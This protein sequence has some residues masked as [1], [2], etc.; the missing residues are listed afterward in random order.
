MS[1]DPPRAHIQA[2]KPSTSHQI[3]NS[4]VEARSQVNSKGGATGSEVK[5]ATGQLLADAQVR[6]LTREE[7]AAA[8]G[9]QATTVARWE[10]ECG[11]ELSHRAARD[12][13]ARRQQW[14]RALTDASQR[15][16]SSQQLATELGL[17]VDAV[18]K[19]QKLLHIEL[20]SDND[21]DRQAA[22]ER[23]RELLRD[24]ES[25]Q[26]TREK[27]A[28]E[29]QVEVHAVRY[30][31]KRCDIELSRTFANARQD[32][33]RHW[34]QVL[35]EARHRSQ[36][37]QQVAHQEQVTTATVINWERR[38]GVSLLSLT[39]RFTA[40]LTEA[41]RQGL[42]REQLAEQLGVQ[43]PTITTWERRTGVVLPRPET[44]AR[45]DQA[46]RWEQLLSDAQ[47]AGMTRE[48]LASAE[49]VSPVTVRAW[50]RRVGRDLPSRVVPPPSRARQWQQTLATAQQQGLL[51]DDVAASEHVQPAT[52]RR[53]ERTWGIELASAAA[54]KRQAGWERR[55]E[56]LTFAQARGHTREDVAAVAGVTVWTVRTWETRCGIVLPLARD[57]ANDVRK[58]HW[59]D[60]LQDARNR[61]RTRDEVA[62][63]QDVR[64]ETVRAWESRCGIP[65]KTATA[66]DR[67]A[68]REAWTKIL[69]SAQARGLTRTQL[70]AAEGI[71]GAQVRAWERRCDVSLPTLRDRWHTTLSSARQLD[72]VRHEVALAQSAS[73]QLVAHWERRCGIQLITLRQR[74]T[75]ALTAAEVQGLTREE[76]AHTHDSSTE[77]VYQWERKLEIGLDSSSTRDRSTRQAQLEEA[78]ERGLTPEE[79]ADELKLDIQ[80]VRHLAARTGVALAPSR[81][82]RTRRPAPEQLQQLIDEHR[83]AHALAVVIGVAS[84]T[85]YRWCR[86]AD[87]EL[88]GPAP[89]PWDDPARLRE[90]VNNGLTPAAIAEEAD[91]SPTTIRRWLHEYG[92]SAH[93]SSTGWAGHIIAERHEGDTGHGVRNIAY[94]ALPTRTKRL[95]DTVRVWL[96][97]DEV[98]LE[99]ATHTQVAA[100]VVA[101]HRH[102]LAAATIAETTY[103]VDRYDELAGTPRRGEEM[104]RTLHTI[105]QLWGANATPRR[106]VAVPLV[107]LRQLW[108]TEPATVIEGARWQMGQ[109]DAEIQLRLLRIWLA[110]V[111]NH[112]ARAQTPGH[113]TVASLVDATA[114]TIPVKDSTETLHTGH[115]P[116]HAMCPRCET[117]QLLA[118]AP[119][120]DR[121]V[122]LEKLLPTKARLLKRWCE[123]ARLP[124][125]AVTLGSARVTV[126]SLLWQRTRDVVAV[127]RLL[128]HSDPGGPVTRRYIQTLPEI[129]GL[130]RLDVPVD[131][132]LAY[133]TAQHER[134]AT[135]MRAA[136]TAPLMRLAEALESLPM[137]SRQRPQTNLKPVRS[138][139]RWWAA[140]VSGDLGVVDAGANPRSPETVL[141]WAATLVERVGLRAVTVRI[142]VRDLGE[143]MFPNHPSARDQCLALA[144][145]YLQR[146]ARAER[147]EIPATRPA[148]FT[149]QQA[150]RWVEIC[151]ESDEHQ[152]ARLL[153]W[154]W[155]TRTRPGSLYAISPEDIS[156]QVGGVAEVVITAGTKRRRNEM[157]THMYTVPAHAHGPVPLVPTLQAPGASIVD[158]VLIRPTSTGPQRTRRPACEDWQELIRVL[159]AAGEPVP[160]GMTPMSMRHSSLTHDW[161]TTGDLL[162]VQRVAGHASP[163]TTHHYLTTVSVEVRSAAAFTMSSEVH[164]AWTVDLDA[165]L[166]DLRAPELPEPPALPL[167]H[168]SG[169]DT[170]G[171]HIAGP[172]PQTGPER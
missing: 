92:M 121:S 87:V 55:A 117:L 97:R 116:D 172:I 32:R 40:S 93:R 147:D 30:W 157:G 167:L 15:A 11:I 150:A 169:H 138:G 27:L 140:F 19:W 58:R 90:A 161:Q 47:A 17:S 120:L 91:T 67:K 100:W 86:Q 60:T 7:L 22:I 154:G 105:H 68:E 25:R 126:A 115:T 125:C 6:N 80:A 133:V 21:R 96:D 46:A 57:Q 123:A 122:P 171:G 54:S 77:I 35:E 162:W 39:E 81:T 106:T 110:L 134:R 137:T 156:P 53:W 131:G 144:L 29:Q 10:R 149:V 88:P 38:C 166:E 3:G 128:G 164:R 65:L 2:G 142:H 139:V 85:V 34:T 148:I 23:W 75:N 1:H 31:M 129:S 26:L 61:G 79:V 24:A 69:T 59:I 141:A 104:R 37:R 36:S 136:G 94:V 74:W 158:G 102:G 70:A 124:K 64:T 127:G 152:L 146:R 42:T 132:W 135:R 44:S 165:A 82:S 95:L 33:E 73:P 89:H 112:G 28:E 9:V 108:E 145:N 41:S 13:Q 49:R 155:G 83:T 8:Q 170:K 12:K 114:T 84:S 119:N 111:W 101:A 160:A 109:L 151:Q 118:V 45:P 43:Q 14:Q 76:V 159:E 113:L 71:T 4:Q 63:D 16:L 163:Q 107:I 5:S 72:L 78:A 52:V 50:E 99:D 20:S 18:R 143:R 51:R 48:E 168:L 62:A 98:N 130:D 66:R 153:S 103:A 56:T